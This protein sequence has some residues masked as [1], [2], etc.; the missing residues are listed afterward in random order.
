MFL[1]YSFKMAFLF[2]NFQFD[3]NSS[4]LRDILEG[5]DFINGDLMA[6]KNYGK[7]ALYKDVC[8]ILNKDETLREKSSFQTVIAST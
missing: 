2:T 4:I 5:Q 1:K 7:E 6:Y 3:P 8:S